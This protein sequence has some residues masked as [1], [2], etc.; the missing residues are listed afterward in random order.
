MKGSHKLWTAVAIWMF[1]ILCYFAWI[2]EPSTYGDYSL[3]WVVGCL[4]GLYSIVDAAIE[5]HNLA[6]GDDEHIYG[7][8]YWLG[9][10]RKWINKVADKHL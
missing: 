6:E 2:E 4:I 5:F 8:F 9:R 1:L 3:R 10:I 7:P